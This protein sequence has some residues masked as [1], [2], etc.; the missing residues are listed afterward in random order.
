MQNL[1][2]ATQLADQQPNLVVVIGS[3]MNSGKTTFCRKL[4][5]SFR[6]KGTKVAACKLTGS[7]SPRDFDEMVSASAIHVTDFSDY[8]FPSTYKCEIEE[9]MDLFK[10]MLVDLEKLKPD[11]IIM[12]VAD[13]VLQ[14]ETKMLLNEPLFKQL[15]RGIIVTADSAP[16]ALYTVNFLEQLGYKVLCVSG[17]ITSSPLYMEE[18]KDHHNVP[19]VSSKGRTIELNSIFE[20]LLKVEA[21]IA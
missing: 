20:K 12:E 13:G 10:T 9:V 6:R 2:R 5:K 18:F 17:S 7:I 15:T 4:I 3:G 1:E 21:R 11:I 19:V 16:A 8:G 14:R